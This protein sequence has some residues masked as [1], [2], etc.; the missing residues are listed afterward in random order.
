MKTT[1]QNQRDRIVKF[2]KKQRTGPEDHIGNL[3][4][5]MESLPNFRRQVKQGA[6]HSTLSCVGLKTDMPYVLCY[7]YQNRCWRPSMWLTLKKK[8]GGSGGER[9]RLVRNALTTGHSRWR[10]RNS[11]CYSEL[12]YSVEYPYSANNFLE[13]SSHTNSNSIAVIDTYIYEGRKGTKTSRPCFDLN[14]SKHIYTR[15]GKRQKLTYPCFDLNAEIFGRS[16][17]NTPQR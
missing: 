10:I 15:A 14:A 5:K 7:E 16:A 3:T 4:S 8:E 13:T 6:E 17:G 2:Q 12:N 9:E 11:M 1:R